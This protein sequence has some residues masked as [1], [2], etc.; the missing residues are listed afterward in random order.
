M[1]VATVT[2][3]PAVDRQLIVPN[4]EVN[5]LHRLTGPESSAM[6]PGGKGI[7]VAMLLDVLGISVVAMSILAGYT[8]RILEEELRRLHPRITTNFVYTSGETRENIAIVDPIK[9]TITEINSSGPKVDEKTMDV[10]LKRYIMTLSRVNT[11]VISGSVPPGVSAGYCMDLV[12]RAKQQKKT[13]IVEGIGRFFEEVVRNDCPHVVRPDLRRTQTVFDRSL[14]TLEDYVE[15][16]K[17]FIRLGAEAAVISYQVVSDIVATKEGVWVFTSKEKVEKSHLFGTG[18][19]FVAGIVYG[20]DRGLSYYEALK[21]GMAAAIAETKYVEKSA[22][23][24][25]EIEKYLDAFEVRSA[26]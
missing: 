15:L 8:G 2:L 7:N 22:L 3:N 11:V 20:I 5:Q 19:A 14:E 4:F 24:I 18:D 25:S 23:S 10:F 1:R 17:E 16:A 6:T 12:R 9:D 13:V 26:V 21:Y